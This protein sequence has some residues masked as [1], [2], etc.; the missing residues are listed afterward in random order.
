VGREGAALLPSDTSRSA[1]MFSDKDV[2]GLA[3]LGLTAGTT[4]GTRLPSHSSDKDARRG[5]SSGRHLHRLHARLRATHAA[6][7]AR[8]AP[9]ARVPAC[10][11]R[12]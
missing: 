7:V 9:A 3:M 6:P 10:R 11:P 5:S 4:P 12:Q 1:R 2:H 8:A